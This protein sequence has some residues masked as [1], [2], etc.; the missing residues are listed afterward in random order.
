MCRAGFLEP[1]LCLLR[2]VTQSPG[3]TLLSSHK[4]PFAEGV[5]AEIRDT[6]TVN[7]CLSHRACWYTR[8]LRSLQDRNL[9]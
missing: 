6:D 3:A 2:E 1:C 5:V 9:L 7:T 4:Q 8:A